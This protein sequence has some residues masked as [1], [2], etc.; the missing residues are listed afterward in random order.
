MLCVLRM[1]C[2]SNRDVIK[3]SGCVIILNGELGWR[4]KEWVTLIASVL[5]GTTCA[6]W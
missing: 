3:M 6:H 1:D 5:T 2:R 4:T